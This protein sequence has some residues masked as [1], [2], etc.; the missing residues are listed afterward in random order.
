MHPERKVKP[1]NKRPKRTR[2][3]PQSFASILRAARLKRGLSSTQLAML[4]GA[5]QPVIT[6]LESG[7]CSIGEATLQRYAK[8]HG[9]RVELR[10]VKARVSR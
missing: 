6:R 9:M 8:A 2:R 5:K 7:R 4:Y 3:K 1:K 10:L